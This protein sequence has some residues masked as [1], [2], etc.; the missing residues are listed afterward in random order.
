MDGHGVTTMRVGVMVGEIVVL[1]LSVSVMA[2]PIADYEKLAKEKAPAFVTVKY[3]LKME[4]A[5]ED[6]EDEEET[7]GTMIDPKG[8][9]LCGNSTLGGGFGRY[10][11]ARPTDIKVLVGKD[12]EGL[13]A[14]LLA[15]DSELDLAWIQIQQPG[16]QDFAHV[17]FG[18][19]VVP[20]VGQRLLG[21]RK[22]GKYFDRAIVLTEGRVAGRTRK[23]RELLVPSGDLQLAPGLP[24]FD[25]D[26]SV[27]GVLVLQMPTDA[28]GGEVLG[29]RSGV[30][31]GLG[32]LILPAAEVVKATKQARE[33]KSDAGQKE[34]DK[35]ASPRS[36]TSKPTAAEGNENVQQGAGE[37]M[38]ETQQVRA[39]ATFPWTSKR[40]T[41][42]SSM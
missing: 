22:M 29:F 19:A 32:G 12:T 11:S 25:E 15:R 39:S 41:H 14:K 20:K 24:V 38:K 33:L 26:G 9:V 36:A 31:N 28:D 34:E 23:P 2:D 17:D 5:F 30:Q 1:C 37:P 4:G 8:L 6:S 18:K 16:R 21:L 35:Q 13:P 42:P 10:G 40:S 7:T 3:V 27:V